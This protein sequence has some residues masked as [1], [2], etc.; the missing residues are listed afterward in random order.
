MSLSEIRLDPGSGDPPSE[1]ADFLAEAENRIDHLFETEQNKK[2]PRYIP[3]NPVALYHVLEFVTS[4][5]LPLGR[6]FCEWGSGFGVGACM[7]AM[8]GYES[9]G[10]EIEASLADASD[11][12]IADRG[13]ANV[14]ILN[15]SYI[16]EGFESYAAVGGE[17]L[18][19]PESFSDHGEGFD[20]VPS[21]EGL[22]CTTDEIDLFFVYPWP[23]EQE[24]M[25]QLFD[26]V[27]TEGAILLTNLEDGEISAHQKVASDDDE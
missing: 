26:A 18:V 19:L 5:D 7:A 24:F 21:Y 12:L 15:T 16:P 17:E 25:Q 20:Q 6:V 14:T 4:H 23:G 2:I 1:I 10:I 13:I 3:S 8:L 11:S 9:Y 27:A 22:P